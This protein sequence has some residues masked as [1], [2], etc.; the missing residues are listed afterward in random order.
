MSSQSPKEADFK[1]YEDQDSQEQDVLN[2][3]ASTSDTNGTPN[4][5]N[6][7]DKKPTRVRDIT[8]YNRTNIDL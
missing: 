7:S 6:K 1:P 3:S 5:S 4:R 8:P 2:V